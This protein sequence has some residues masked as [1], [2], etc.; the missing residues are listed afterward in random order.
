MQNT[1]VL[2][3]NCSK[4]LIETIIKMR[5]QGLPFKTIAHKVNISQST[6]NRYTRV[7]KL[8][9]IGAFADD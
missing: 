3:N 7:Y 6:V 8:Y 2:I 1:E 4:S 9:G 5:D